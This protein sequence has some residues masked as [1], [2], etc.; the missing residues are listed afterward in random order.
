MKKM[1]NLLVAGS[2]A[3]CS[4][5]QTNT[6]GKVTGSIKDG[7]QQK[8]IDAASVSLLKAKDSGL[9][10]V[11][12]TDKDGNFVIE[13]VKE[14]SYLVL[15]TSVG[16]MK[17]YSNTFTVSAS[18]PEV[19][20]GVLQLIPAEKSLAGVTVTS[21]KKPFIE[22]KADKT[23]L[24][25]ESSISS[26]G[27]TALEVL[28]KAP[29]VTVDK[30]GNISLKGKQGVLIMV[31]GKPTYLSSAELTNMLRNMSSNQLDQIEIM[32]NPSAKYDA[33][34]RA[35]IINIKTKKN[36]QKGFNGSASTAYTQ[37]VYSRTS[38]SLNLNYKS[39]KVNLFSTLSGNYRNGYQDLDIYRRYTNPD[40]STK[41]IFEQNSFRSRHGGNYSAKVGADYYVSNKTTL[42][43]VLSGV[44][45]PQVES[46]DNTSYL[47]GSTGT[48]DSIVQAISSEHN[49]W[50]NGAVNFNL[51]HQFDSTGKEITFD[52]DYLRYNAT[53]D[54]NFYNNS[55]TPDWLFK[56][57]D[58]LLGDLPSRISI[59]SAKTDY[60]QPLNKGAKLEAGLKASFV[61][62]DN[63]AGYYN[64]VGNSKTPDYDKTNRF[65]Y[66][67]NINAAYVN[68]NKEMKK[69]SIQT[70]LRLENTNYQGH[71]FGNPTKTDSSFKN[72][73]T[74]L[75][76][77]L[78][79]GYNPTEKNQFSFSY[80]RRINRPDYEDLNPFLFFLDK[81]T[82][83]AGNPFLKPM[84]S[85]VLEASHTY[86]QFL[87]TTLSYSYTKDLF[88]ETFRQ[89]D[90]ATIVSQGNYGSMQDA[91]VSVNAQ[92]PV[93]KWLNT[94][95]YTEARYQQFKG[96]L[97]GDDVNVSATMY[98]VNVNNQLKLGKGWSGE[99]SGWYR[100]K[101]IE[102]Q[103][104]IKSLGQLNTGVQK[105]V[106]KNK[107]TI[108][109]SVNDILNTRNPHGNINFQNTEAQFTQHSDNRVAT[110]SFSYRF[111]KPIKGLQ[112]RKTGGAGSEQNR[113]K[114]GN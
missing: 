59:Y 5:A 104:K 40:N 57:G 92:V 10:K 85:H 23:V 89:K 103:I 97:Y 2:L 108:K 9:V 107:G 26:T 91:S 58:H 42:G 34:G 109:L 32:T 96:I 81:Y 41:A 78:F 54:Q 14:G 47:K 69:W 93:A 67:E 77:T 31:D 62:T 39:G 48:I 46:G 112:K 71:Q 44:T 106:L 64:V 21:S 111:G 56:D 13:N 68:Y 79:V 3:L 36:K 43:I 55:Y 101:G 22:R 87:T 61:E 53:K 110:L 35:G 75:F 12:I 29:G 73:Y 95:I 114:G 76:P 30:D 86:K 63:T 50:K 45:N 33:S 7:G 6:S 105:Q 11:A 90:F 52:A 37:G 15:A 17:T 84:Y 98:L 27:S 18:Q 80:G 60:T 24:N 94:N 8:I 1:F 82:Y 100:T 70:G 83:G 25:V 19:N 88:S 66:K 28:E 72:S 74:S 49:K 38:N 4:Q 113:V 16:H 20:V 99:V 65:D 102:G 51:R